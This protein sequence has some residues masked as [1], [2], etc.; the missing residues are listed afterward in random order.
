MEVSLP[1]DSDGFLRRECPQCGDEFKWHNG[2]ANEDAEQQAPSASFYCPLCGQPAGPESWWTKG[3]LDLIEN[4]R[5][6]LVSE[7]L[8]SMFGDLERSTRGNR[9]VRFEASNVE[10]PRP[11]DPLVEPDD[12]VIVAPP[13]HPWE[14]V[15]VPEEH[16]SPIHCLV[17][18]APFSV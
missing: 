18:G 12:M 15:K 17:C 9:H 11:A 2:P 10:V 16:R 13:C 3:Q 8:G 7:Q 6:R 14:P 5:D 4:A 1:L